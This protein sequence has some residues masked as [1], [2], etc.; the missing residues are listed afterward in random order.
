[1]LT[2]WKLQLYVNLENMFWYH[3]LINHYYKIKN[4]YRPK[5]L[6]QLQC[7]MSMVLHNEYDISI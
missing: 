7:V 2:V 5:I 3:H 6:L 1:M 4:V